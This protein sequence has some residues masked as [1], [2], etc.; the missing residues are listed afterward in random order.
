MTSFQDKKVLI[1]GGSRGIGKAIAQAFAQ[2]GAHVAIVYKQNQSAAEQ[3]LSSLN[4]SH[5]IKVQS[6]ISQ[7]DQVEQMVA[8]VTRE[9]GGLDVVVNN[10][11]IGDYHPLEQIN[12]QQWQQ[13]WQ[14]TLSTNLT[15]PSNLCFCA[16]KYM[17][18]H[19]GGSIVNVS[20]RGAFRGE[21][22]KPAYGAS[23]AAIN[24]LTQS[25]AVKLA[26]F[27]ISVAAVAPGFVDTELT[28]HK[29]KGTEGDAI[30]SQSPLNR[31]AKPEEVANA[32]LFLASD[33]SRFSSGTIIDVNG[34]SYLRM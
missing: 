25:L 28:A 3:T 14:Q 20:S 5:H 15:G 17:M 19:G 33:K 34:A 23:K 2:Q 6:D 29:L 11:G 12:Y 31:V 22:D 8:Q 24:A 9:L 18:D 21:P 13:A 16:A 30:R 10:A 1:T 27:N 26:P 4:G 32:V 7:P